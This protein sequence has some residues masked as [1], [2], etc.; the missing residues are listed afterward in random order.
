MLKRKW[1]EIA[2]LTIGSGMK[3]ASSRQPKFFSNEDFLIGKPNEYSP[4]IISAS[5]LGV[6]VKRKLV[7]QG[8]SANI[9]FQDLL[10]NLSLSHTDL[11]L[12]LRTDLSSMG[13]V[14]AQPLRY[15]DTMVTYGEKK[16]AQTIQ[17]TFLVVPIISPYHCIVERPTLARLGAIASTVQLKMKFHSL[18][19]EIVTISADLEAVERCHLLALKGTRCQL[20]E[21][22][23]LPLSA[24][25]VNLTEVDAR[26]D[27]DTFEDQDNDELAKELKKKIKRLEPHGEFL[28]IPLGDYPAKTMKFGADLTDAVRERLIACLR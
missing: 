21:I 23:E 1:Q 15:L 18:T 26:Y 9:M 22:T 13:E 4:L 2:S 3:S 10:P 12:Y 24:T 19:N 28:E 5:I 11:S 27:P 17:T 20:Q 25:A 14:Q 8:S 6:E 16:I 7:D